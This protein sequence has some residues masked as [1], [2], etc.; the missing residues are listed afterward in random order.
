MDLLPDGIPLHE[1]IISPTL[2]ANDDEI[3]PT[4]ALEFLSRSALSEGVRLTVPPAWRVRAMGFRKG[5]CGKRLRNVF[6]PFESVRTI[7]V[8]GRE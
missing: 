7:Q 1:E 8:A 2:Q 5:L 6:S 4:L 3:N